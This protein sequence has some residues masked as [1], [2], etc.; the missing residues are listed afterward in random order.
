MNR[1]AALLIAL[2]ALAFQEPKK[3]PETIDREAL[4]RA[5]DATVLI[6][7]TGPGIT[8]SGSGFLLT[9]S[10]HIVTNRHV[11][12][13]RN[14]PP[15]SE[16]HVLLKSGTADQKRVKATKIHVDSKYDLALLKIEVEGLTPLVL[17]DPKELSETVTLW[18]FGY[19]FGN[20]FRGQ[21]ARSFREPGQRDV[22][23]EEQG[24]L[25]GS[26]PDRHPGQPGQ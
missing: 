3:F 13:P 1:A 26:D 17:G 23:S 18:A 25:L 20:L 8:G 12:E 2:S 15:I 11:V 7:V 16:I 9:A 4:A 19:P 24:R 6:T 22:P 14:S 21:G 10:G 5:K